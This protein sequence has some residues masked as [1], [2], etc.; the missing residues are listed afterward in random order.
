MAWLILTA[1]SK[2]FHTISHLDE[3]LI[4]YIVIKLLR[5]GE[6]EARPEMAL[7]LQANRLA[8]ARIAGL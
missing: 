2:P 4:V 1:E 7:L 8:L 5:A 3:Y 6:C